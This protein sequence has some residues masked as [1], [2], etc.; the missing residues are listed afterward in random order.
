ML[1]YLVL[2]ASAAIRRK[3]RRTS[4]NCFITHTHTHAQ[5][6]CEA[7]KGSGTQHHHHNH[8]HHHR[9]RHCCR[10]HQEYKN[11]TKRRKKR[12]SNDIQDKKKKRRIVGN[13]FGLWATCLNDE[14]KKKICNDC[15]VASSGL[16]GEEK[17]KGSPQQICRGR[18]HMWGTQEA[19]NTHRPN[20]DSEDGRWRLQPRT[21]N[22]GDFNIVCLTLCLS[23]FQM[24]KMGG[25]I[26]FFFPVTRHRNSL[27]THTHDTTAGLL[28]WRLTVTH[29]SVT[30]RVSTTSM[31]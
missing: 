15:H 25:S 24:R 17:K 31:H 28:L 5:F 1:P 18:R 30:R 14:L 23:I 19:G 29:V 16:V 2:H 11:T 21:E 22:A 9:L 8:H 13:Y 3:R 4:L 26:V 27:N 7:V 10:L 6:H 12:G 20:S